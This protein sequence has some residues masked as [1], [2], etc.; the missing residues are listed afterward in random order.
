MI[1]GLPSARWAPSDSRIIAARLVQLLPSRSN[2][3]A[4][5][6][7]AKRDVRQTIRSLAVIWLIYG[8]VCAGALL[9]SANREPPSAI[10]HPDTSLTSAG[11]PPR[12]SLPDTD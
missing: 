3:N 12:V 9:M 8:A 10:N 5:S 4:L 7:A 11:S 2:S 6:G 1:G